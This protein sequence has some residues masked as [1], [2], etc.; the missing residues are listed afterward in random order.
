MRGRFGYWAGLPWCW[1]YQAAHNGHGVARVLDI[2]KFR[3]LPPG[4][5]PADHPWATGT[6]PATGEPIWPENV[7]YRSPRPEGVRLPSDERVLDATGRFLAKRAAR[8]AAGA[9][10][11][12]GQRVP[13]GIDYIHGTSHYN[14]GIFLFTDFADGYRHATDPRFRRELAR[15][16]KREKRE[17]LFLFR[18]RDYRPR[19]LAYFSCCLRTLFPW[20]CNSNGP[21]ARVLWG[22]QAPF[23]AANLITGAWIADVYA[24]KTPGG[25][26]TVARPPIAPGQYFTDGPYDQGRE[27][28]KFPEKLLAW[29]THLRVK[30]RGA[31]GGLFFIDRRRLLAKRLARK[32]ASGVADVPVSMG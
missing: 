18:S 21:R 6:N 2:T 27:S 17:V 8:S 19:E 9:P 30:A 29:A 16:V 7:V 25:A 12:E 28:A 23:V 1:A 3:P 13:P 24:L 10:E 32:Q 26:A 15:F 4:L 20:F 31:R 14:S 11:I 22:N 5:I